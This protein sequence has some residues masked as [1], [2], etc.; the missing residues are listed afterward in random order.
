MQHWQK[1]NKDGVHFDRHSRA[2]LAN[3]DESNPYFFTNPCVFDVDDKRYMPYN[4]NGFGYSGIG[5]A[6][7]SS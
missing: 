3:R 5:L 7:L 1:I 2:P 4:S 6:V